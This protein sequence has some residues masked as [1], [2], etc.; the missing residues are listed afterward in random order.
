MFLKLLKVVKPYWHYLLLALILG[1]FEII[2]FL[3]TPYVFNNIF[4]ERVLINNTP[5]LFKIS[6]I[7][8]SLLIIFSVIFGSCKE[9]IYKYVNEKVG[10]NLRLNLYN[11][12][13]NNSDFLK[14]K[15]YKTGTLMSYFSNDVSRITGDISGIIC[16]FIKNV[17]RLIVALVILA[18][19]DLRILTI[20]LLLLPLY[21]FNAKF[22]NK[23]IIDSSSNVQNQNQL[24]S[25]SLEEMLNGIE[26]LNFINN[27]KWEFKKLKHIFSKQV[28]LTLK[29]TAWMN[30]SMETGYIIYWIVLI[31]IYYIGGINVLKGTMTVGTLL[32]Y[33]QYIDNIYMPARSLIQ[34]NNSL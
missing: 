13:R 17:F 25:E 15:S 16:E 29:N 4:I 30:L 31:V 32:F 2:L 21:L 14:L 11:H 10:C 34:I 26:E 9:L 12:L 6:I 27:F 18:I 7:S 8:Y 28:N 23:P 1:L 5:E 20:A 33:A 24:M 22:F 19:I 3:I